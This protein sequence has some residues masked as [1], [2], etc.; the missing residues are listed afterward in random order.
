MMP[1]GI[2]DDAWWAD[3]RVQALTSTYPTDVYYSADFP[4]GSVYFWPVPTTAY[5]VQL[6][7][8]VNFAAVRD[9]TDAIQ[10]PQGYWDAIVYT[11]AVTLCPAFTVQPSQVLLAAQSKAWSGVMQNNNQPPRISLSD[12]GMPGRGKRGHFDWRTGGIN[13]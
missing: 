7:T 10:Y 5:D 11:L 3:N 4:L 8:W 9:L 6:E 13:V 1:M 2:R 12:S